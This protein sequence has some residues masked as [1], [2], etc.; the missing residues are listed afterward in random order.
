MSVNCLDRHIPLRGDKVAIIWE[1]DEPGQSKSFTYKQVLHETCRIANVLKRQ[2]VRRG[3]NVTI[4][5][6]MVP[7]LAFTMLACTSIGAPHSIVF[8]GFFCKCSCFTCSRL[9]HQMGGN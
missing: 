1:A 9:S 5:M 8:A 4:Y 2:G 6:P 7:E 3:D